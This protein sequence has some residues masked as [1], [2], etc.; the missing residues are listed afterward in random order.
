MYFGEKSES[1]STPNSLDGRSAICPKLE[2]TLNSLPK[3]FSIVFALAGDSTITKFLAIMRNFLRT[4]V[5][6][7]FYYQLIISKLD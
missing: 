2:V 3:N 6:S 7:F 1:T 5:Y 4:K